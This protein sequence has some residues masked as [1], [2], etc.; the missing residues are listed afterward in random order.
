MVSLEFIVAAAVLY[1]SL[2]YWGPI[3]IYHV[4][5]FFC[6]LVEGFIIAAKIF[7]WT[8][9]HAVPWLFMLSLGRGG[10]EILQRLEIPPS[11]CLQYWFTQADIDR[12]LWLQRL[13]LRE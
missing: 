8:F 11:P 9:F 13:I 10:H 3:R 4:F 1:L 6:L 7:I 5:G 12:M 2:L